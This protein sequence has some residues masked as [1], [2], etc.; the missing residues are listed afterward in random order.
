[1]TKAFNT[2]QSLRIA[3]DEF[4]NDFGL[5]GADVA[6]PASAS[7]ALFAA[8]APAPAAAVVHGTAGNDTITGTAANDYIMGE[9]GDDRIDGGAGSD[10]LYGGDGNDF[11]KGGAGIDKLF[12][13][14]G[15]DVLD[16][17]TEGDS[18]QGGKGNDIY[19]V[20]SIFDQVLEAAG[21]GDDTV[22][23][24]MQMYTLDAN[25]ERLD[26]LS[27]IAHT[28]NGNALGNV[29]T[30]AF[31]GDVLRGMDGNDNLR[32][33]EGNDTLDGGNG[34]DILYGGIGN[35]L[36]LGGAGSDQM[37]GD[38]GD[39]RL[40]GGAGRDLLHGGAGNDRFIFTQTA[41]G[42]TDDIGDFTRG[43]DKV[44]FSAFDANAALPGRQALAFTFQGA[45]V[46]GGVGSINYSYTSDSTVLHVDANGDGLGDFDVAIMGTPF[47]VALSDLVL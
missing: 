32:G 42:W 39:D 46:G 33:M 30:G 10:Q 43:Q 44:D 31:Q 1:M 28:G 13:G 15:N 29:I 37:Y 38:G 11:L 8:A 34:W 12:G 25:I 2:R 7:T 26:F 5:F 20:D 14:E 23:T 6:A 19:V 27:N 21:E 40:D 22:Q 9:G 35:D 3:D 36:L 17:G 24:A 41:V 45:F 18:M 4:D 47:F 16:G